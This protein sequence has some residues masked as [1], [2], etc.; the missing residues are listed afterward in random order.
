[1]D[2]HWSCEQPVGLLRAMVVVVHAEAG[3]GA[4]G[5][6][7]CRG[8]RGAP[9]AAARLCLPADAALGLGS[10]SCWQ[11][12]APG[13]DRPWR[14]TAWPASALQGPCRN[15]AVHLLGGGVHGAAVRCRRFR[16]GAAARLRRRRGPG[17]GVDGMRRGLAGA[18]QPRLP[19]VVLRAGVAAHCPR[20]G[21]GE[22]DRARIGF[23][24]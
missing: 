15:G 1:M 7:P 19:P 24:G 17:G 14:V 16:S 3:T 5:K 6:V 20:G 8:P 9:P 11:A 10:Q 23:L 12:R 21:R 4:L 18:L 2:E 22:R 13:C